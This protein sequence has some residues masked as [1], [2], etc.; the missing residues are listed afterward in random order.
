MNLGI[1]L[2]CSPPHYHKM[3]YNSRQEEERRDILRTI[4]FT[5]ER[6]K[7]SQKPLSR[8]VHMAI[9]ILWGPKKVTMSFC[10]ILF[11]IIKCRK[12]AR[13]KEIR[14]GYVSL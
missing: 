12:R 5:L 7:I 3:A 10:F 9:H 1:L 11:F 14:N 6:K 4:Y 8:I 13:E 2:A